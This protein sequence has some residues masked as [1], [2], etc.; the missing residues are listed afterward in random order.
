[1]SEFAH[2]LRE[3]FS[4]HLHISHTQILIFFAVV[5]GLATALGAVLFI[6]LITF[7][8]GLFVDLSDTQIYGFESAR[9]AWVALVPAIGGLLV[10][11]LVIR[12]AREAKGHGV[13]EVMNAVARHRG[14]IR[15]RVAVVKTLAS[16]ICI[17]SGG[18]A[19]REGPIV[20][21]G[22]AIGSTIGQWTKMSSDRIKILVG[23]GAAAGISA[24][25]NAPIAGVLFS[26]EVI[27]GDF[28]I[29]TFSPVL[30]SSVVASALS[31]YMLGDHPAFDVPAYS[32]VSG[33]EIPIYAIM[34]IALGV[35]AVVYTRTLNW[36]EDLWD[37][38][39]MSPYLKPALGGLFLGLIGLFYPQVFADG[40]GTIQSAL[41]GNLVWTLLVALV[42]LKI[43]ATSLTLG[44][45]SS[46][47]IFAPSL[48]I[49]AVAGGAFGFLVN[50]LFPG[51]TA[52]PG[53]YALVG[54]ACLVGGATHAP[55]TAILII[56]EMTSDYTII[57]PLMISVVFATLVAQRIEKLS[58]YTIKLAK[59][60]IH[61]RAGKDIDILRSL[62]VTDAMDEHVAPVPASATIPRIMRHI[63]DS[64]EAYFMVVDS[65]GRLTGVLTYG[66][67]HRA[68]TA[69]AAYDLIIAQDIATPPLT[70]TPDDSLEVAQKRMGA[71]GLS[72]LPVVDPHD[73][74]KIL[75]VIRQESLLQRYNRKLIESL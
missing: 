63:S 10:A 3:R 25:F 48:F 52:S 57:L 4:Q 54:M 71:Q 23:C 31:R 5:V 19:G 16:A 18:S 72:L 11:P 39:D 60:G 20:Q 40:Y 38:L 8:T 43:I 7:F 2:R 12:F 21:I 24:V 58:I 35:V 66:D 29:K 34:G 17:G 67:L 32:L 30:I 50:A 9:R 36:S 61:L 33:W 27:L 26:L 70:V 51:V 69:E 64:G 49:G 6:K 42:V 59:R 62:T 68:M 41:Q 22:S 53:A 73:E 44:S 55:M 13:P 28:A 65:A 1:M 47:G 45:G 56:F 74:G 14:V 15:P 37:R 46:G 75:G